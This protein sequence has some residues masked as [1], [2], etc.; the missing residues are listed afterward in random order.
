MTN[1][2]HRIKTLLQLRQ[3]LRH[4]SAEEISAA[5][6]QLMTIDQ[7]REDFWKGRAMSLF[8]ALAPALTELRDAG[9]QKI[10]KASLNVEKILA[11]T[12]SDKVSTKNREAIF[13]TLCEIPG[14]LVHQK[15]PQHPGGSTFVEQYKYASARLR[16]Q[17]PHFSLI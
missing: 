13:N 8:R 15:N 3:C 2:L 14:F 17:L 4:G 1:L 12:Q 10:T 7:E 9:H 6:D 16:K 5:M 11:L